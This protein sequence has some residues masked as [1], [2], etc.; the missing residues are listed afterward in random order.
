M[1]SYTEIDPNK[2]WLSYLWEQIFFTG[3]FFSNSEIIFTY[4][5]AA[6]CTFIIISGNEII[7]LLVK[8]CLLFKLKI[9]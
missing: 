4:K 9:I 6:F 1:V 2:H 5:I 3:Y 7:L 8:R